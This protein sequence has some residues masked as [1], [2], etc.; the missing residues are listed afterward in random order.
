MIS[1]HLD[2]KARNN[3]LSTCNFIYIFCFGNDFHSLGSLFEFA[4]FQIFLRE[5]VY[6]FIFLKDIMDF[7]ESFRL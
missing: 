1:T 2:L 5:K 7:I 6:Y 3:S 4:R